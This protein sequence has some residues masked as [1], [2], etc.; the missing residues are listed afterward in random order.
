AATCHHPGGTRAVSRPTLSCRGAC[1]A[2]LCHPSWW[3]ALT[4]RHH[5]NISPG[6]HD[7]RD[8]PSPR[9]STPPAHRSPAYLC[10]AC[11]GGEPRDARCHR[12]PYTRPDHVY[13]AHLRRQYL[14]VSRK[15]PTADGGYC[16]ELC[17]LSVWRSRMTP[18]AP[19]I[20]AFLRERLPLQR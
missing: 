4:H 20:T 10:R 9:A 19:H 11:V 18:I 3:P 14:L 1:P 8:S 16:Q 12:A 7:R 2:S 5:P 15:H 13:G 6:A 17:G